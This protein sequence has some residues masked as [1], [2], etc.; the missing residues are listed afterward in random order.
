M[1][2]ARKSRPGFRRARKVL[3]QREL[4]SSYS[5][6]SSAANVHEVHPFILG[7][8]QEGMDPPGVA[9]LKGGGQ[10]IWKESYV[11]SGGSPAGVDSSGDAA[12]Q[13]PCLG[14]QQYS[15]RTGSAVCNQLLEIMILA[16]QTCRYVRAAI[17]AHP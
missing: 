14:H 9:T 1:S 6:G 2:M 7:F 3:E 10:K 16:G 4:T 8:F 15:P 5:A 13:R 12:W 17:A 11:I